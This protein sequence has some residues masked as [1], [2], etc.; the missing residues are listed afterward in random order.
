MNKTII[1]WAGILTLVV[2][3]RWSWDRSDDAL[4]R[5]VTA[6]DSGADGLPV[7]SLNAAEREANMNYPVRLDEI[8]RGTDR[9]QR[10]M[11]FC[12][13]LKEWLVSD[14]EGGL[15]YVR[16]M[17]RGNEYTEGVRMVLERLQ[18][19]DPERALAL[20]A[21]LVTR[22]EEMHLYN[23][24]FAQVVLDSPSTAAWLV[25]QVPE[26]EPKSNAIRAVA[27]EWAKGDAESALNW[28]ADLSSETERQVAVE[29]ALRVIARE[30]P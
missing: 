1:M 20:M 11:Q 29:S 9:T 6:A 3:V 30:Q 7:G 4:E 18:S 8:L 16:N 13:S 26:G 27:S 25:K 17:P 22:Q 24:L 21:E 12:T 10:P 5:A 28:A 14:F 19:T 23:H 15:A 2:C